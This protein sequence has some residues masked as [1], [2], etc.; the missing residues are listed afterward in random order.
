M[1]TLSELEKICEAA[2]PAYWDA[3]EDRMVTSPVYREVNTCGWPSN[4]NSVLCLSGSTPV[5]YRMEDAVFCA[6]AR[7]AIPELIRLLKEARVLVDSYETLMIQEPA[8]RDLR[9]AN[10][11]RKLIN[12]IDH[13]EEE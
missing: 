13:P 5:F 1:K 10:R 2:T 4:T 3:N 11:C 6:T 9:L 7:D 8:F 12:A